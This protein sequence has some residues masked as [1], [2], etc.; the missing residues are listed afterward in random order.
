MRR[1]QLVAVAVALYASF[2]ASAASATDG[3]PDN[4]YRNGFFPAEE[5]LGLARVSAKG[6]VRFIDDSYAECPSAAPRCVGKSYVVSGDLA[7]TGHSY[8]GYVCAFFPNR[9]GG[10][11]G[12]LRPGDLT[13]L[14]DQRTPPLQS[15]VGE[16]RDGD[17]EIRLSRKGNRLAADGLAFWPA[18]YPDPKDS[19]GG[20]HDGEMGGTARP[21]GN[22]VV[23]EEDGCRV[24][25]RLIGPFLAA[26]D[27][28]SCGGLN[29]RFD[30]IYRR[31]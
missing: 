5:A 24:A 29:V 2:A 23:F 21:S 14:P 19:P 28:A 7:L 31:E 16:W 25:L 9:V 15:W 12:W 22:S 27:N 6:R 10:S 8:N 11:A 20:P 17:N 3:N 30:G 26:T 4:W 1:S 13:R 18:R